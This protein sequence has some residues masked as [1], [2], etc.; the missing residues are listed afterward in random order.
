[1]LANIGSK[2]RRLYLGIAISHRMSNPTKM[3]APALAGCA[4]AKVMK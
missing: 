3:R 1:M 2:R 4:M